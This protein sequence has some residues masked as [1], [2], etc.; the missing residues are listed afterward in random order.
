MSCKMTNIHVVRSMLCHAMCQCAM[1]K[2][3]VCV[4]LSWP[5]SILL[6]KY[7]GAFC[8]LCCE[9]SSA[10]MRTNTRFPDAEP[11]TTS[12]TTTKGKKCR[13]FSGKQFASKL[14]DQ[15]AV[16]HSMIAIV[17][18]AHNNGKL[19]AKKVEK[20]ESS[21]KSFALV[22]VCIWC[23]SSRSIA[24]H[25]YDAPLNCEAQKRYASMWSWCTVCVDERQR[26][27]W[28]WDGQCHFA[29]FNNCYHTTC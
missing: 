25:R 29:L 3:F 10:G 27:R 15:L 17:L 6:G 4:L 5:T 2:Q 18:R 11:S 7:R 24:S 16:S 21:M 23:G 8:S 1:N 12:A 28:R 14:L 22:C 26:R 19:S 20:R 9:F 13:K